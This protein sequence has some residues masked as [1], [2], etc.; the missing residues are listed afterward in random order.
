MNATEL[1]ELKEKIKTATTNRDKA[2]GQLEQVNKTLKT[3]FECNTIK[4]AEELS[5]G[6]T[7]RIDTL[8]KK[9]TK[10]E[11]ELTEKVELLDV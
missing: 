4:E 5:A 9:A 6:Y 3:K 8:N 10:L 7:Q 2:S 1:N 11:K